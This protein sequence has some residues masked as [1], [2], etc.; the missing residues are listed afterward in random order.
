MG[1]AGDELLQQVLLDWDPTQG[2]TDTE[3]DLFPEPADAPI[4]VVSHT[5]HEATEPNLDDQFT[6][7]AA[8]NA[9]VLLIETTGAFCTQAMAAVEKQTT[10]KPLVIMS[11]T[12]GSI[13]QFFKPLVDQGLT[14]A[15]T[16]IIQT[17][18][19]VNDPA[20]ADD[21]I[22]QLY[23]KTITAAGL[24]PKQ[25]TYA[26]GWIFA[27]FMVDILKNAATYEGGLDRG[28]IMLAAR[29]IHETNP[30]LIDGL[31]SITDG[32]KDA[33]LTEGGRMVKYTVSDP[34]Q[35][36][37]FVQDGE[38]IDLE[39]KLGTYETVKDAAASLGGTATTTG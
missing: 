4:E 24:D 29:N 25:T 28:N 13:A 37:T 5:T 2:I 6:T 20:L 18:K 11:G 32:T 36:G 30:L 17:F 21:P 15:D 27:W 10:W 22:V 7:M 14:G 35:L 39:G 12:C 3:I 33:Y 19:D 23:Q 31:T 9:Q 38:L 26:T 1:E 34:A 8:S 16:R